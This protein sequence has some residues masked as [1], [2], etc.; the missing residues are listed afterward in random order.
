MTHWTLPRTLS[1]EDADTRMREG[2]SALSVVFSPDAP[3]TAE[4]LAAFSRDLASASV[5]V[6][7]RITGPE[8]DVHAAAA[9]ALEQGAL[10]EELVL[11]CDAVIDEAPVRRVFCVHCSHITRTEAPIDGTCD[12]D[13]CGKRLGVHRHFSRR[14]SAY[15][16]T[17]ASSVP[18]APA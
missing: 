5:G 6:R 2:T 3:A 14:H 17:A 13:G 10:P 12:C 7:I 18:G 4:A 8:A 16:G 9:V 1:A 15:M 11:V